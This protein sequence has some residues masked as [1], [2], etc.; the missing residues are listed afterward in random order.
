MRRDGLLVYKKYYHHSLS[1]TLRSCVRLYMFVN[2]TPVGH[3]F[4]YSVVF[5]LQFIVQKR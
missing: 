3:D 4:T 5:I 1:P 2:S